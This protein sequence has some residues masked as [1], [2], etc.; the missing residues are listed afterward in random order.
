MTGEIINKETI[1]RGLAGV[2]AAL[3]VLGVFSGAFAGTVAAHDTTTKNWETD[4]DWNGGSVGL[5]NT[6][7]DGS[8]TLDSGTWESYGVDL[9]SSDDIETITV[10]VENAG[11]GFVLDVT[12]GN[13]IESYDI[14]SSGEHTLDV[15]SDDSVSSVS[16]WLKPNDT[17][18]PSTVSSVTINSANAAPTADAGSDQTVTAGEDVTLD[19]SASSDSD[20]DNLSYVWD[21]GEFSR[22]G[23][24]SD[25]KFASSGTYEIP[26]TVTDEHGASDTDS[27][28]VT[29]EDTHEVSFEVADDTGAAIENASVAVSD[30]TGAEVASLTADSNGIAAATLTP[31]NYSYVATDADGGEVAS[32]DFVV[33]STDLTVDAI[34]EVEETDET[35]NTG[36]GTGA[37]T[38]DNVQSFVIALAAGLFVVLVL[39]LFA[40]V[41]GD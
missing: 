27:V 21:E 38:D 39:G 37:V 25:Y 35:D 9:N 17:S 8:I 24:T 32:G 7:S 29:V 2:A 36:A 22:S 26:L 30:D 14:N 13:P 20:G 19:A 1:G 28:T 33:D 4:S 3:M 5:D 23:M 12:A 15:S 6:V 16:I 34:E 31:G 10:D 11:A 40:K 41:A 18:D